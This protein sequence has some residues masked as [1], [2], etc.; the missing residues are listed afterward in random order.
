MDA[1]QDATPLWDLSHATSFSQLPDDDFLALLQK[2]FPAGNDTAQYT[3][4]DGINPQTISRYPLP[5]LTPPS[6]DSSP[7]PSNHNQDGDYDASEMGPKRKA[8]S[9]D[10]EEGP[11]QKS[12]HTMGNDK[13]G[14]GA[15]ASRRKSS[16]S[17]PNK[18]ETRLM[19]RKEQNRAAQRAFR[20][21]K[22]KHVKDLEDQVAALEAKNEKAVN[23]NENLRDL[24]TRLQN[25]NVLLKQSSFTFA[26]PKTAGSDQNHS[27]PSQSPLFTLHRG[28]SSAIS[29]ITPIS[30]P[31]S[32]HASP[33][34]TNPLDW[35]SLTTFDPSMLNLLDETPQQTATNDA[36]NMDFGFGEQIT[37]LASNAPYTT[38]ASNPMFLSF[39][40]TFDSL[41]PGNGS[42]PGSSNSPGTINN[43]PTNGGFNFDMSTLSA[44][45]TPTSQM[46]GSSLEDLFAGWGAPATSPDFSFLSG[47]HSASISPVAHHKEPNSSINQAF[48]MTESRSSPGGSSSSSPSSTNSDPMFNSPRGD[49]SA[50]DSDSIHGDGSQC[51]KTKSDLVKKIAS[52][53]LSPFAPTNP[54]RKSSDNVLGTMITCAGSSF[55]KTQKSDKNIEVLSAWRSIT[56]NPTF[57]DVDINHLC[58]E[59]TSKARCDGT[60]VV[61]EPQGV[62]SILEN[63]SKKQ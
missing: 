57:K 16:G 33:K 29:P 27:L 55:P 30:P 23:E 48:D 6:E 18:D 15:S 59:F 20:E 14:A 58:S 10:L 11:S 45:P 50:S 2:Q 26:V 42:S 38:I 25:E 24:L 43:D 31:I 5:S 34:A 7:S 49:S 8:S 36:M 32:N 37:G 56:Q 62:N 9:E 17:A 4:T 46:D 39:A 53:G 3:F 47:S 60:K 19:K 1:Y 35:S 41:Q 61:L 63:L 12:Q 40:S 13:K 21:R 51:P 54:L 22:E 28:E 44:W 52:D